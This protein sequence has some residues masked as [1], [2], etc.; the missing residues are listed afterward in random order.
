MR[1]PPARAEIDV[2]L[3]EAAIRRVVLRYCRAIDRRD[4]TLLRSCYHADAVEEHGSFSG[5]IDEYVIWVA[6]LLEK[7]DMTMHLVGNL[8]VDLDG[9]DQ[10][11][12][13]TYGMAVHRGDPDTPS[14]NLTTGFRYVDRFE[15][16]DGEWRIARRV[17]VTE[18]S[19]FEDPGTWWAVPETHRSG[20]HDGDDPVSWV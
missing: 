2:V 14:R 4:M 10:A 15:R 19:R 17:A 13:E 18:W 6:S 3:A 16:R 1:E 8:L 12:V 20:R 7:F 9:T 5:S 11:R